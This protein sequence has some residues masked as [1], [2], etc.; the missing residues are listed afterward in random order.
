MTVHALDRIVD[1]LVR[2]QHG[3]FSREQLLRLGFTDE[4]IRARLRAGRWIRLAP[5]VYALP[6][7]VG[8]FLRQ[9]WGAVLATPQSAIAGLAAA[10]VHGL[11]DFRPG[12]PELVVPGKTN[13][14]PLATVHRYAGAQTCLLKGL[15]VTTVAQTLFDLAPRV[16]FRR[17]ERA[18][19]DAFLSEAVDIAELQERLG[20]YDG[21]RR[22]GLPVMRALV[23]ERSED[24]WQPPES[25]LEARLWHL[26]LQLEGRPTILRQAPLPWRTAALGRVDF[27][28]PDWVTLV[29]GDSR[30]WHARV[31]DFDRDRWRDNL[32][33]ANGVRPLRFTWAHITQRPLEVLAVVE[34][35]GRLAA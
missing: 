4:M 35:T 11:T 22:G 13:R 16:S 23:L 31:R 18:L 12:R 32:A 33:V 25:E 2:R 34:R 8:T 3:A 21:T 28:I 29:E 30:R 9:C 1:R 26:L 17:L 6:S 19:D 14:N 15:P 20:F 24:G 7:S 27:W 10:A 5:G